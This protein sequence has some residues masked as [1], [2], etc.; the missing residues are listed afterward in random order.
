M[1]NNICTNLKVLPIDRSLWISDKRMFTYRTAAKRFNCR[2]SM[3][4]P[5][6]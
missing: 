5:T 3:A 4:L 2:E 1:E 6:R